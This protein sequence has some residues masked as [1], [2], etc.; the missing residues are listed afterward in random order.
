M[1]EAY[2]KTADIAD[3]MELSCKDRKIVKIKPE[4]V[5][6]V[7]LAIFLD[8]FIISL[9]QTEI[10]FFEIDNPLP[11]DVIEYIFTK[12]ILIFLWKLG[13]TDT[14][15]PEEVLRIFHKAIA[16]PNIVHDDV[17]KKVVHSSPAILEPVEF[18]PGYEP[19]IVEQKPNMNRRVSGAHKQPPPPQI[20]QKI[21]IPIDEDGEPMKTVK[22]PATW[23]PM[24]K[25]CNA[26]FIYIFFRSYVEHFVPPNLS[27]D[28]LLPEMVP[29]HL[30]FVFEAYKR[31]NIFE[32]CKPNIEDVL[33]F[34]YFS[35]GDINTCTLLA[36]TTEK[37]ESLKPTVNDKLMVKVAKKRSDIVRR[38]LKMG[39]SYCS[40]NT[41]YGKK[42][43]EK[44]FSEDYNIPDEEEGSAVAENESKKKKKKRRKKRDKGEGEGDQSTT[45]DQLSQQDS[46][47]TIDELSNDDDDFDD[48]EKASSGQ[49]PPPPSP[50]IAAPKD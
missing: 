19:V 36:K 1:K 5:S 9:L 21:V 24:N 37:Y 17:G 30:L 35:S 15:A 40:K 47:D 7:K 50:S 22:M 23:T 18:V 10:L 38:L 11:D 27:H 43:C 45:A 32:A 16:E 8:A 20:A 41:I 44:L 14:R 12:E 2:R 34:G 29:Q 46:E 25:R 6:Q 33:S 3:K 31:Q 28:G 49:A 48:T 4:M 39:P 13:E 42:D 26:A